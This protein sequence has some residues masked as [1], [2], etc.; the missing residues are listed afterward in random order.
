MS[1]RTLEDLPSRIQIAV[2]EAMPAGVGAV[3]LESFVQSPLPA[4]GNRSIVDALEQD[5]YA[6]EAA[7]IECCSVLKRLR[8]EAS[9]HGIRVL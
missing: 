2:R 8:T 5:G 4:L 7:I 6:A 1:S 3:S 9:A